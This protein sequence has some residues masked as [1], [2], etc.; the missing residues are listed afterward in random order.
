VRDELRL[1][2]LGFRAQLGLLPGLAFLAC[3][4]HIDPRFL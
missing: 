1:Y 4:R 2:R 3:L